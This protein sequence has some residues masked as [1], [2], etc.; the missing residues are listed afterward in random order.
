MAEKSIGARIQLVI[1]VAL[2]KEAPKEWL[3]SHDIPVFTVEALKSGALN[4]CDSVRG[5]LVVITG[6]GPDASGKAA[7]WIRDNL[8]PLFVI[9]TGT[10]G[11][12]RGD[13]PPG[14]W[15]QPRVVVNEDGEEIRLDS[16]LPIPYGDNINNA[17]SLLTVSDARPGE[18]P[19]K[20]RRYGLLDMECHAQAR[21]F[22]NAPITFHCLK[23][24]TDYSDRNTVEDF[25]RN[26]GLFV[27]KFR[28]LFRFAGMDMHKIKVSVIVPAYNRGATISRAI[29]S[30][31]GQTYRPEE[32]IIVDDGST[33]GTRGILK[34]YGDRITTVSLEKNCGPSR[35]RNEGIRRAKTE[36]VAFLDSDDEWE[37]DKLE[38]QAGYLDRYPFYEII[39]S[40]E[41]WIRNGKRVNPCRHHEKP[42]GWIWERSLER[43]LISP[44]A[45]LAKKSLLGRYGGFD[46]SYPVCEDYDL[47]LKISRHHPVGLAPGLS[48]VKYGGHEDQLSQTVPAQDRYRVRTLYRMLREEK[49][50]GFR[51]KIIPVLKK[52]LKI[53]IRGYEKRDRLKEAQEYRDIMESLGDRNGDV[54]TDYCA[55]ISVRNNN[56]RKAECLIN[57]IN[58]RTY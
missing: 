40:D 48:V 26:L 41:K 6:A 20:W 4:G 25:N 37:R 33:D 50:S 23:F 56:T 21:V 43:C 53:L 45:A 7:E 8:N 57:I 29:D 39:Q 27:E 14:E 32:I 18:A 1:T 52:K 15:I 30:A 35:A 36:W 5:V 19:G 11:V 34:D 31:L 9:N 13:V 44:S 3:V 28:G 42:E 17:D 54:A 49:H 46:E 16:R 12:M 47:W 55:G 22:R 24:G 38:R 2:K 10:C 58:R 51:E